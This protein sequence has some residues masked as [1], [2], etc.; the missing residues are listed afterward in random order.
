MPVD[1]LGRFPFDLGFDFNLKKNCD[2]NFQLYF[3]NFCPFLQFDWTFDFD[4]H[5]D[6]NPSLEFASAMRMVLV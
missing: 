4:L 5:F 6:F 3:F 2:F 1:E